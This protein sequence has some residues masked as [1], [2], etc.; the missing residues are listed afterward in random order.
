[1]DLR[2]N[3]QRDPS[4][5]EPRARRPERFGL[6]VPYLWQKDRAVDQKLGR[7][8]PY[9]IEDLLV[10]GIYPRVS[11]VALSLFLFG[12]VCRAESAD[13]S[14]P[15]D[16]AAFVIPSCRESAEPGSISEAF[17]QGM[18]IGLLKGL[19]YLS[20]DACIPPAITIGAVARIVVKYIDHR[21][22]RM[23][24]DFREL[25]LEALK[26]AW[27]CSGMR[28]VSSNQPRGLE[29]SSEREPPSDGD[30]QRLKGLPNDV[31]TND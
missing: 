16:A 25:A 4:L 21:P 12:T 3:V 23:H 13:L 1:M 7:A 6:P 10:L 18:C 31:Y 11:V 8:P 29:S 20:S 26:A 17:E 22:T 15:E 27:P 24:E 5:F 2:R 30:V 9:G 28:I 14:R 19:Y